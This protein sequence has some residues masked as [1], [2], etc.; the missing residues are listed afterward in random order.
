MDK[1]L[2]KEPQGYAEAYLTVTT[3]PYTTSKP[4]TESFTL[5]LS[6]MFIWTI[7]DAFTIAMLRFIGL[8]AL[9]KS[10]SDRSDD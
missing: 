9:F 3:E 4:N 7:G 10:M 8:A 5:R 1:E 2:V 6:E